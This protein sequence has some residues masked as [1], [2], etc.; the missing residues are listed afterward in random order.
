AK[1]LREKSG[2]LGALFRSR[3]YKEEEAAGRREAEELL[4]V[5]GL[6][7]Q[8]DA[9]AADLP[10]GSKRLLTLAIA[11][12]SDPEM[13][14]LDEPTAGMNREE[15]AVLADVIKNINQRGVT[16][17]IIEHD[18][19]MLLDLTQRIIVLDRGKKI[20]EGTPEKIRGEKSVIEAYFGKKRKCLV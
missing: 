16:I 9:R 15:A 5:V 4:A 17:F 7:D 11:L 1:H 10:Y 12:S 18:I 20:M 6:C 13:I 3:R 8:K 14:L 19:G 2:F